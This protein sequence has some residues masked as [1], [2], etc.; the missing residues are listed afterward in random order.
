MIRGRR[1]VFAAVGALV[2]AA[3]AWAL[4][5]APLDVESRRDARARCG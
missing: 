4:W 3:I 5:P 1:L 2:V